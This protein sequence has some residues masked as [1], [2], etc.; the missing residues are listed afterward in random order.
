MEDDIAIGILFLIIWL[1][2]IMS[3]VLSAIVWLRR[4]VSSKNSS[5]VYLAAIAINDIVYLLT[6]IPL[7]PILFL[8]HCEEPTNSWVCFVAYFAHFSSY[9]LEPLLVLGFS[10]ERLFAICRPLQVRSFRERERESLFA[11]YQHT[12]YMK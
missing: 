9:A 10:V 6:V 2:G 8:L 1:V 3:N 7:I 12:T 4:Q 5:A 11:K